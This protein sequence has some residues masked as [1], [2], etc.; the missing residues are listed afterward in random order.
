MRSHRMAC[1]IDVVCAWLLVAAMTVGMV[2]AMLV[3]LAVLA[4]MI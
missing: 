1:V 2:L 3:M 4:Y